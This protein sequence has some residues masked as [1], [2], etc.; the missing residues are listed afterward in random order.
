VAQKATLLVTGGQPNAAISLD[1]QTLG[2]LDGVGKY[3]AEV[4]PGNHTVGI[5]KVGFEAKNLNLSFAPGNTARLVADMK[6]IPQPPPPKQEQPKVEVK[7]PVVQPPPPPTIPSDQQDWQRVR[8]D[9]DLEA[10]VARHPD[11]P[12]ANVARERMRQSQS[13][14]D[15]S[16][17]LS[18]LGRY[19]DAYQH[20]S[21][22]ELEA[23]W[24][25]LLKQDRKKISDSFKSAVAIQMKLRPI[26]DPS[27][28]GDSAVVN[29]DRDLIYTFQGG[30]QKTFSGQVTIRL[31]KKAG[32]WLIEGAS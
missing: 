25:G 30:V 6:Q 32:T 9:K 7:P 1:G 28:S 3:S 27:V 31:H 17:V 23:I 5:T 19:S 12:M 21:T 22:D 24:P 13:S 18:A 2:S 14:S 29:C 20:K 26:G 11:S 16:G 4:S 10:F 8:N 15:R